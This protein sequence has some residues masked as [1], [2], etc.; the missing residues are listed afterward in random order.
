MN[1]FLKMDIF[2]FMTTLVVTFLGIFGVVALYYVIRILKNIE[3]LSN[4]AIEEANEIRDDIAE[5][6]TKV[7]EEGI[8]FQGVMDFFGS[9][10]A[11]PPKRS[12]RNS[13]DN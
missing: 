7:R 13:K 1:D 8:R 10:L 6:R 4:I 3:H 2:F 11:R 5:V 12:R 9:M